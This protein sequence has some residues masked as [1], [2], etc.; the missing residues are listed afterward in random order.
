MSRVAIC[1]NCG[2]QDDWSDDNKVPFLDGGAVLRFRRD[3]GSPEIDFEL[4]ICP[5]CRAELLKKFPKLA[6][7][8]KEFQ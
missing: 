6:K 8:A 3:N 2:E 5:A 7:A 4:E 1:D